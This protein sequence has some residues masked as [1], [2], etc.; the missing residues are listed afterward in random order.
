MQNAAKCNIHRVIVSQPFVML[1]FNPLAIWVPETLAHWTW[2]GRA[3][4]K[5]QALQLDRAYRVHAVR[6]NPTMSELICCEADCVGRE[7]LVVNYAVVMRMVLF[8]GQAIKWCAEVRQSGRSASLYRWLS[9]WL[10]K[11]DA[12]A[13]QMDVLEMIERADGAK[14]CGQC[15][16]QS[17]VKVGTVFQHART[18][19]F[20]MLQAMHLIV[21]SEKGIS[22]HQL[23]RILEVQYKSA[24]FLP[25]V[26]AKPCVRAT[27]PRSVEGLKGIV[28]W[29]LTYRSDNFE[30]A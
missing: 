27:L 24:L 4:S 21:S 13:A 7:W 17:T 9:K 12:D 30:K 19:L 25:T 8:S 29:R 6:Y 1:E 22:S 28:G 11:P 2:K 14:Q 18:P 3:E 15:R 26:P 16:K 5:G 23:N 20:K 10:G